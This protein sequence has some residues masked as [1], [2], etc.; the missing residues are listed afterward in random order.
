[1]RLQGSAGATAIGD[2][3][4]QP[5]R[6]KIATSRLPAGPTATA[7]AFRR[8]MA[9]APVEEAHLLR[10]KETWRALNDALLSLSDTNASFRALSRQSAKLRSEAMPHL[11]FPSNSRTSFGGGRVMS[12]VEAESEPSRCRCRAST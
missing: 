6:S 12:V 5:H 4:S 10:G 11:T 9:G 2:W 3:R 1:M 8:E 7:G